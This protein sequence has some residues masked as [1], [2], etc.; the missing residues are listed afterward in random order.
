MAIILLTYLA[1][2]IFDSLRPPLISSVWYLGSI[3]AMHYSAS[4]AHCECRVLAP[5]AALTRIATLKTSLP[6]FLRLRQIKYFLSF[7]R[8]IIPQE[9]KES[10]ASPDNLFY[11]K[12]HIV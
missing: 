1:P 7:D 9:A 2:P 6:V 5:E 4:C 10:S 12:L 11:G 3:C 8:V